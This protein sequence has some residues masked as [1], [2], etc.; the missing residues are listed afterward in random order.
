M[1]FYIEFYPELTPQMEQESTILSKMCD[2]ELARRGVERY[3][4]RS[5]SLETV[6]KG[7]S[8]T[9]VWRNLVFTEIMC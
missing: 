1:E 8:R 7:H 4:G 3:G 5:E 2:I 9:L 6:V